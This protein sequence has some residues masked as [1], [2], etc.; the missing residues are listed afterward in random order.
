MPE[1]VTGQLRLHYELRGAGEDVL[2]LHGFSSS[3]AGTWERTSWVELLVHAGH[4]VVG[5]DVRG[6][7]ASS[8]PHTTDAYSTQA[9]V[10][11]ALAL[12]DWLEIEETSVVG[13]SMGAGIALQLA[14]EDPSRVRGL[15][16]GGIAD[17]AINAFAD[18]RQLRDIAAGLVAADDAEVRSPTARRLRQN[19]LQAGS[20]LQALAAFMSGPGWPG[21]LSE[22]H[23]IGAPTLLAVAGKDQYMPG[24][25]ELRRWLSHA[26]VV[27]IDDADHHSLVR[28]P[29]FKTAAV[30]FIERV[31]PQRSA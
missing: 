13:Y 30:Q 3:F 31:R 2:L 6:H 21:G 22:L 9:L 23:P 11:D 7:G 12:L 18:Q 29:R 14:M 28:D 27:T 5:P 8:K 1:L 17:A 10:E 26:E 24:T 15:V 4:R 19:A 16:L 20:D 25:D